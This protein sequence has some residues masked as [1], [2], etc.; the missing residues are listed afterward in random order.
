V[1][2]PAATSASGS[3]AR[4]TGGARP[5]AP[6]AALLLAAGFALAALGLTAGIGPHDEGLML[7]WGRR[8]ADGQWPYRDFWCNY[9]PGQPLLQAL[10]GDSL[11]VWRIV[12]AA[13]GAAAALLAWLL[14]VRL[15]ATRGWALAAW[16][17]AA[18]ALAWP[19]TPGPNASALALALG[20]LLA[21]GRSPRTDLGAG[22]LAG[23]AALFRPEVGAAAALGAAV[24][25][26]R[27]G[28]R[29]LPPLIASAV[30]LLAG[31]APFLIVAPGALLDQTIGFAS[32]QHMQ[33]LP[34]TLDPGTTDPNKVLER[35]FPAL[36]VALSAAWV[37]V[38]PVRRRGAE[39]A[40]LVAVGLAYLLARADEFHLVPL[41]VALAVG[42][43][44]LGAREPGRA[45][46]I[47][48][49]VALGLI[50]MHGADRKVAQ[51]RD[52][53]GLVRLDLPAADGVRTDRRTAR[54]LQ[55]LRAAVDARSKPGDPI[56][57]A[58]P[59]WDR[60]R[61]GD[62]LLYVLLDRPNPTRYDVIQPGVVTTEEAQREMI[63][64]LER[65]RTRLVVRWLAPVAREREP[66]ASGRS[67][68]VLLLDR[69]IDARFRPVGRFGDHLL[70]ER[71]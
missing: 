12:R 30:G 37:A 50:V 8:I 27:A 33:R 9:M 41:A 7:Q 2:A 52:A 36:L 60:V 14:A 48:I 19:L 3:P 40:P 31:L 44:L 22:A 10:L 69:W 6:W 46:R 29:P 35:L 18:L 58:P 64:D 5:A 34:L 25:A 17:A 54:G 61:V 16:A 4:R 39:L 65:S 53:S 66:N 13:T 62:T 1:S 11:L 49:A 38:A 56:L 43:A 24:L 51:V 67:S 32:I 21:A 57:S 71:R 20:A 15:G 68:G 59:R 63:S 28:G 55:E 70:L 47:A 42:L 45:A 26:R 23:A